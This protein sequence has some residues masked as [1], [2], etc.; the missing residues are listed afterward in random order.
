MTY[1]CPIF[2][3]TIKKSPTSFF[4][5]QIRKEKNHQQKRAKSITNVL[6]LEL[7]SLG[8]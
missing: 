2:L 4:E 7:I 3:C 6:I 5:G 1:C 8:Y